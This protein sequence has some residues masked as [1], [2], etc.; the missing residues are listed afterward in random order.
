MF[1]FKSV[2][3]GRISFEIQLFSILCIIQYADN[4]SVP[5]NSAK[6]HKSHSQLVGTGWAHCIEEYG[7]DVLL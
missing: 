5:L 4:F 7:V 2:I 6:K 3:F 1:I